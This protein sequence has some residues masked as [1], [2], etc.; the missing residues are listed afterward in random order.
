MLDDFKMGPNLVRGFE[1]AG[2][3]PRDTT[4]DTA[5]DPLGGT[6]YWGASLEFQYPFYFLPK[7]AGFKG[8]LF[9]DSGSLWGYRGETQWATTGEVNGNI[10]T[11]PNGT[12]FYCG[13]CGMQYVDSPAP[14]VSVGASIIWASPF[15]PLRFDFAYPILKESYDRTQFFQ[16]GGGTKF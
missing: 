12:S 1:P 4:P 13:N 8:A 5:G 7:D 11:Q 16:F 9:V 6:M 14:R 2:I 3:G 10:I 15:G